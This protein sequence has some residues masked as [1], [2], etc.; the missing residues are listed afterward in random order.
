MR[1][2]KALPLF[3][4]VGSAL[5]VSTSASADWSTSAY[6]SDAELPISSSKTYTHAIN[7]AGVDVTINGVFF[8]GDD[9]SGTYDGKGSFLLQGPDTE[10]NDNHNIPEAI[11]GSIETLLND[12]F[13]NGFPTVLFLNG[14]QAGENY[15]VRFY[16]ASWGGH[17]QTNVCN[18]NVDDILELD[19][20]GDQSPG[21]VINY[22]G[23]AQSGGRLVVS[24]TPRGTGS[25]HIYGFS[26]E[27]APA[28]PAYEPH[29]IEDL[30][31][32]GIAANGLLLSE[33]SA[34]SHFTLEG[35]GVPK[36]QAVVCTPEL[37]WWTLPTFNSYLGANKDPLEDID[38]G[39]YEYTTTFTIED[40][41]D[42]RTAAI[43]GHGFADDRGV[44]IYLN[45]KL[46]W[47]GQ[48]G[49][50][51]PLPGDSFLIEHGQDA[52][53]GAVEFLRGQ[54][55]LTFTIYE[56]PA[57]AYKNLGLCL[58]GMNGTV[59]PNSSAGAIFILR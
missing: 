35:P 13:F 46:A 11:E 26:V 38:G 49:Y 42:P 29:L 25:F 33:G 34:D 24:M 18:E 51:V 57:N 6:S 50:S 27:E 20:D 52:G 31:N 21:A 36:Q 16:V 22:E 2:C 43:S 7:F 41:D 32:T 54:N 23:V 17:V 39:D 37:P 44:K 4:A 47:Q 8:Q 3:L 19:R 28:S 12:F 30:F 5:V 10:F 53:E 15:I 9:T 55:T 1:E 45:G 58:Y 40:E 56:K 48:L 59:L 14:L